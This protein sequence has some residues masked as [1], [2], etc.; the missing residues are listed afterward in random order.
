M[1]IRPVG[2]ELCHADGRTGGRQTDMTQLAV[3]FRS[4]VEAPKRQH[5]KNFLPLAGQECGIQNTVTDR[6]QTDAIQV[7]QPG[8]QIVS[9][10]SHI[11]F[12]DQN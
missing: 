1:K 12:D 10:P 3:D 4:F 9:S 2:D 6:L 7:P 11:S 5:I 8:L